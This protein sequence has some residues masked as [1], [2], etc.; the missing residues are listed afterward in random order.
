MRDEL[1]KRR[2]A[3]K[4]RSLTTREQRA[5]L[6][7]RYGA[8]GTSYRALAKELGVSATTIGRALDRAVDESI[9]ERLGD[10]DVA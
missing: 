7:Q 10:G 3:N 2:E 9:A 1:D 4:R 8:G 6:L 5:A